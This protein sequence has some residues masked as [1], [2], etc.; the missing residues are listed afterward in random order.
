MQTQPVAN[1]QTP[2]WRGAKWQTDTESR[3]SGPRAWQESSSRDD[4]VESRW[5]CQVQDVA[6]AVWREVLECHYV[7]RRAGRV[8]RRGSGDRRHDELWGC[9][10]T[11]SSRPGRRNRSVTR[12]QTCAGTNRSDKPTDRTTDTRVTYTHVSLLVN[13]PEPPPLLAVDVTG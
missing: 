4:H 2:T 3:S 6:W 1:K 10:V 12:R 7:A 11:V 13:V 8:A 5:D 9:L